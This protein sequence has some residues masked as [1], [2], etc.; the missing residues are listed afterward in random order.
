MKIAAYSEQIDTVEEA[1]AA[2]KRVLAAPGRSL[3]PSIWPATKD[4]ANR[5]MILANKR[6]EELE[7]TLRKELEE[8]RPEFQFQQIGRAHV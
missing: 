5:L 7:Y 1:I 2:A 3:D 6:L 4:A 8:M